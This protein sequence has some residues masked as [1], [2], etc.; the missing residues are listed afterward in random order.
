MKKKLSDLRLD[1]QKGILERSHLANDPITHFST[2]FDQALSDEAVDEANG[3]V[4]STVGTDQKPSSRVVLLKGISDQGFIF[5]TN[6][7]SRKGGELQ[8]NPNAA[9]NF[10]WCAQQRQVRIEGHVEKIAAEQ[11]DAYFLSRPRG[12]QLGAIASPQSQPIP[13][14]AYLIERL[15]QIENEMMGKTT[16]KRPEH[17]GGYQL[18]PDLVE[19]WQ[20]GSS[21]LH[22]RFRYVRSGGDWIIERLAP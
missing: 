11:S 18:I 21:R 4:L 17:W 19:F 2:W 15:Q 10:W 20:G 13:D 8:E 1:Y 14:R 5:Y 9:L 3:M 7:L 6:Y 22:D 16:L 12:S